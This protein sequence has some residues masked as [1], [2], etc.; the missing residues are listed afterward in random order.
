MS[1]LPDSGWFLTYSFNWVSLCMQC[2]VCF[3][4]VLAPDVWNRIIDIE[5]DVSSLEQLLLYCMIQD[6]IIDCNVCASF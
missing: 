6:D 1:I 4:F 3:V 5:Y 2:A